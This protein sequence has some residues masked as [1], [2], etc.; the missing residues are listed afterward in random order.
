MPDLG[1]AKATVFLKP[2]KKSEEKNPKKA[3]RR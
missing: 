3:G 2:K 1:S